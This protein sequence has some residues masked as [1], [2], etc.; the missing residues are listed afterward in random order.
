MIKDP[1]ARH[2][3][4]FMTLTSQAQPIASIG[5]ENSLF[6]IF[7]LNPVWSGLIASHDTRMPD[8][9]IKLP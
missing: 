5:K 8:L 1:T 2:L 9:V 3:W 4:I 7:I 6:L